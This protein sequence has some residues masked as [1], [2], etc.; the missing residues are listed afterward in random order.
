MYK[1]TAWH[2]ERWNPAN[3]TIYKYFKICI[4]FHTLNSVAVASFVESVTGMH[5]SVNG[6]GA[7]IMSKIY[8]KVFR[9]F[10][11]NR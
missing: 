9:L 11:I 4:L 3:F 2:S 10:Y 1:A 7:I 6:P 5:L 8:W